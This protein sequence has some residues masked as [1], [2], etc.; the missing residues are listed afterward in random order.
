MTQSGGPAAINGFLYQML[1]H[2]DWVATAHLL[3]HDSSAPQLVLEPLAGGDARAEGHRWTCVEQYKTRATGT[4]SL[5]DMTQMLR[6]LRQTVRKPYTA[7]VE[8]RFVTNGRRGRLDVFDAF[9]DRVRLA[10]TRNNLDGTTARK[11]TNSIS[12]SD[13]E[14]FDH[15]DAKTRLDGTSA[16]AQDPNALIRLL[17]HFEMEFDVSYERLTRRLDG[18]L[19]RYTPSL[20]TESACR[21]RLVGALMKRL[22]AGETVLDGTAIDALLADAGLSPQRMRRLAGLHRIMGKLTAERLDRLGYVHDRDIRE[23]PAWPPDKP[24]LLIAGESGVGKTWQLGRLLYSLRDQGRVTTLAQV[25]YSGEDLLTRAARDIW[26]SGLRET[27]EKTIV[28]VSHHLDDLSYS[29][30]ELVVAFDDVRD[31]AIARH[32]VAQDWSALGMRLVLTVPDIVARSLHSETRVHVHTVVDFS[33]DELREVLAAASRDWADLPRDLAQLLRNPVLTGIYLQLGHSSFRASPQ[34]EYEIFEQFW[35]RIAH[36]AHPYDAD[37]ARVLGALVRDSDR[38]P[39]PRDSWNDIQLTPDSVE[40]L[41][42]SG[43]LRNDGG[44]VSFAHDR[45]LNWA[46]AKSL[47]G[48]YTAG[49]ISVSDL[50]D[51]L[52]EAVEGS[53]ANG[54]SRL[55]YVPMDVL[56]LLAEAGEDSIALARLTE[57]LELTREFG[58]YGQ[59]LYAVLL[60]T[61]GMH[62]VPILVQ[63]LREVAAA[64]EADYRVKLIGAGFVVLARQDG[65][66]LRD[67]LFSLL[68]SASRACENVALTALAKVPVP[69]GLGRIWAL[70]QRR[71][72]SLAADNSPWARDDYQATFAALRPAIA[73]DPDWLRRRFASAAETPEDLPE[74]AYQLNAL[75]D[76]RAARDIW[77]EAR[78]MLIDRMPPNKPRSLLQCIAKFADA[79]QLD[80]VLQHL[81]RPDDFASSA[82]LSALS[83][84]DPAQAVERLGDI[85]DLQL[86]G[87]RNGWLPILLHD[88]P[89][90]A[91]QRI[92]ELAEAAGE[93]GFMR[94]TDLFGDRPNQID[95]P[96]L[97]FL[98]R[99]LE[100]ELRE[101]MEAALAGNPIWLSF[102]LEFLRR[103]ARPELLAVLEEQKGGHLERMIT[104]VACSQLDTIAGGNYDRVFEGARRVLLTIGGDGFAIVLRRQLASGDPAARKNALSWAVVCNDPRVSHDLIAAIST[105]DLAGGGDSEHRDRFAFSDTAAALAQIGADEALV[106]VL[107]RTGRIDVTPELARLRSNDGPMLQTLTA[108]AVRTLT[109]P[110]EPDDSL[111]S[112]VVVAWVSADPDLIDPVRSVLRD[113]D[114]SGRVARYACIALEQLGDRS[115]DFVDLVFPLLQYEDSARFALQALVSAGDGG[116]RRI[117]Q[118]LW[119]RPPSGYGPLDVEAIRILHR[120]PATR[121]S[122][123]AAAVAVCRHAHVLLDLPFEIAAE[124]GDVDLQERILGIAF[125]AE[126]PNALHTIRAVEGLAKFDI[127]SAALAARDA[128]YRPPKVNRRLCALLARI[129][130]ATATPLLV[131][132]AIATQ[133]SVLRRWIGRTLRRL[134][135]VEVSDL[136]V[137][138]MLRGSSAQRAAAADTARWLPTRQIATVLSECANGDASSEVRLAALSAL[139]A[140]SDEAVV[141]DLLAA[142]AGSDHQRKWRLLA[143]ILETGDPHLL[144][145]ADDDLGLARV[146]SGLPRAFMLY[147]NDVLDQRLRKED[148]QD[149]AKD[150][151]ERATALD[152]LT[153][154]RPQTD[155]VDL[156]RQDRDI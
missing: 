81:S 17:A 146:L 98:L 104:D 44:F 71:L 134:D 126:Q 103:I 33:A 153:N 144:S 14:F 93:K 40:R 72:A 65:V 62:A 112:A 79:D 96:T 128:I 142:F 120:N 23:P 19:R 64:S 27:T 30:R 89:D 82:A 22:R 97:R 135:D 37:A 76:Y 32:L 122:A 3:A 154:E 12:M 78:Q 102:R 34:S 139:D 106:A 156:L 41:E 15:V 143:T 39:L 95:Q 18:A 130:P 56:W 8:Y 147:A 1:H 67:P 48:D 66:D 54:P 7:N 25:T 133:R 69:G 16:A 123:V 105:T 107:E 11:F 121:T 10:R 36:R 26:Q 140:H 42:T 38:Y 60:P 86:V 101:H 52:A 87:F 43:W 80:F 119:S 141:R 29:G 132:A 100:R 150:F 151:R 75:D 137:S 5:S 136:L 109:S 51:T 61:L 145:N 85:D 83:V 149:S 68:A 6:G 73:R 129:A 127:T 13:R 125:D 94:V 155:S 114:P 113:A 148:Q 88:Q 59:S 124:S 131:D 110:D 99:T 49:R 55:G 77:I 90:R 152:T 21:D 92:L 20:G 9:L 108:N 45:L 4:W 91:R 57:R 117:D 28:A 63:R 24:V 115:A 46:L 31:P 47:A 35:Q 50:G 70:H 84:I 58:S 111:L 53:M 138:Y 116:Y 118:W 2:I 74:L